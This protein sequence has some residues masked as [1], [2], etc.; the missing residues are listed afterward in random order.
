[1]G[2]EYEGRDEFVFVK[3]WEEMRFKAKKDVHSD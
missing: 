1:M 2:K 3:T